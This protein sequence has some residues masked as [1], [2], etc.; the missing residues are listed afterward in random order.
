MGR[1]HTYTTDWLCSNSRLTVINPNYN[2]VHLYVA[3]TSSNQT[4]IFIA[5]IDTD[6]CGILLLPDH[7]RVWTTR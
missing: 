5:A 7:A 2:Y 3:K 6:A 1:R 4:K